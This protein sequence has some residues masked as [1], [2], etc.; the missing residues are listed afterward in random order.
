MA[1]A[2]LTDVDAKLKVLDVE[3]LKSDPSIDKVKKILKDLA[4]YMRGDDKSYGV[5][6]VNSEFT[7]DILA[8][9][10]QKAGGL[11]G[12]GDEKK[13]KIGKAM[14]KWATKMFSRQTRY[15]SVDSTKCGD[16][17]NPKKNLKEEMPAYMLEAITKEK[18]AHPKYGNL[19][20]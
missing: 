12:S 5:V 8:K 1:T 3:I 16:K 17:A 4:C 13:V 2:K 20:Y 19:R 9:V 6:H 10:N 14:K 18:P 15:F 11:V 7:S